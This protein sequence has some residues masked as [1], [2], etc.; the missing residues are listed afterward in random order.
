MFG[1]NVETW[2]I[3][4]VIA[5]ILIIAEIGVPGFV[6]FPIGLGVLATVPWTLFVSSP[7]WQI[8]IMA[9]NIGLSL[10]LV[11]KYIPKK[12][13]ANQLK[14]N[15]DHM[16]GKTGTVQD[17]IDN[18]TDSGYMKLYGDS[19]RAIS[20]DGSTIP[21]GAKIVIEKMDGN[22]VVVSA[23]TRDE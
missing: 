15:V 10:W 16:I 11:R 9:V 2:Q 23:V 7:P 20:A 3:Y 13:D 4:T 6:L 17:D 18:E 1:L 5:L 21:K 19:W 8:L 14:T 22:K 12:E